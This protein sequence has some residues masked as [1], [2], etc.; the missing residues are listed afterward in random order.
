MCAQYNHVVSIHGVP[1]SGTSWLGKIV[2]THS[3]VAYR[4][5]PLFSY[6][7]KDRINLASSKNDVQS[8][9]QELYE[10]KDDAFILGTWLR[11]E[12]PDMSVLQKEDHPPFM[13][14]KEVRYHHL[15]EKLLESVD[16]L[17]VVGIVRNPCAV[18]NSWLQAPREF[19]KEWDPLAEWRFAPSKNQGRIEEFNGFEKWKEATL[20][21]L[22]LQE[23]YR[24]RFFLIQYEQ[25]VEDPI[26]IM[27]NAFSFIGL[28]MEKQVENFIK[29]SQSLH[30]DDAYALY[31]SPSV[32]SRWRSQLDPRISREI[33]EEVQGTNLERFLV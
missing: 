19:K 31:K 29:A 26:H 20:L 22:D 7:F 18:I 24:E 4:F 12:E 27:E 32:K 8:F 6:R 15:V 1:R 17:Q 14:M 10:V 28:K 16:N 9:L 5:Q 2:S 11:I 13:V 33:I 3:K 23:R 30:V 21:F 25:L